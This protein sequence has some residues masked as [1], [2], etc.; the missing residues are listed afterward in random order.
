MEIC[1]WRFWK[2]KYH[3]WLMKPNGEHST[4]VFYYTP[5]KTKEYHK[6]NLKYG[7]SDLNTAKGLYHQLIGLDFN[8]TNKTVYNRLINAYIKG[9]I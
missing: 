6:L 5:E 7:F 8:I 1:K 3:Y 4:V 9:E 2:D